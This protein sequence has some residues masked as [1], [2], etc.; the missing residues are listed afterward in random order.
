MTWLPNVTISPTLPGWEFRAGRIDDFHLAMRERATSAAEEITTFEV[1]G[2]TQHADVRGFS[3]PVALS[4]GTVGEHLHDLPEKRRRY[5]RGAVSQDP[6]AG[7]IVGGCVFARFVFVGDQHLEH[8]RHQTHGCRAI[9][10]HGLEERP[11]AE[12]RYEDLGS[13]HQRL[14]QPSDDPGNV[15]Q[16]VHREVRSVAD[17]HAACRESAQRRGHQRLMAD[18]HALRHSGGPAGVEE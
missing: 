10:V 5:G 13:T 16:R 18:H 15:K 8:C 3:H 6:D 9:A 11:W 14:S 1:I 2:W 17:C 7:Q 4:E 12:V